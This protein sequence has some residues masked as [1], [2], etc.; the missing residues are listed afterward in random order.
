[1]SARLNQGWDGPTRRRRRIREDQTCFC[2]R[3]GGQIC[4]VSTCSPPMRFQGWDSPCECLDDTS[5]DLDRPSVAK[6][7]RD[8]DVGRL[9]SSSSDVDETQ[10]ERR[11]CESAQ[12]C[13]SWS[14]WIYFCSADR[15]TY[16]EELGSQSCDGTRG[17]RAG[18]CP[19]GVLR[20]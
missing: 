13:S 4:C 6:A 3:E 11:Q 14:D 1:M 7:Q 12:S 16:L 5:N 19:R 18:S 15:E 20:P 17:E 9:D 2:R 8:Q 10:H